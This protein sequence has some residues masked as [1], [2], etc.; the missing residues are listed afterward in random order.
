MPEGLAA[1]FILVVAP[2]WGFRVAQA[3][4]PLFGI[5]GCLLI[6]SIGGLGFW[7]YRK[8]IVW[9]VYVAIFGVLGFWV[10]LQKIG[11]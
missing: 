3:G 2:W 8:R 11:R 10:L 1:M 9:L 6:W 5:V 4:S 7:A